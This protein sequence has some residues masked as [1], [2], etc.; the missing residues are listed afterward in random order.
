MIPY[1]PIKL[2]KKMSPTVV[3]CNTAE[4]LTTSEN[5]SWWRLIMEVERGHWYPSK[6]FPQGISIWIASSSSN[7]IKKDGWN[8]SPG[9]W[10]TD[11]M[12]ISLVTVTLAL[13]R[14]ASRSFL[15]INKTF[16]DYWW[17]KRTASHSDNSCLFFSALLS[18]TWVVVCVTELISVEFVN[19]QTLGISVL[20]NCSVF[21]YNYH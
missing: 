14:P 8:E 17:S 15:Y 5:G 1:T 3:L 6:T 7:Q 13:S 18:G 16:G 12:P 10:R 21:M 4:F 9:L 2:L 20:W 19:C 11:T